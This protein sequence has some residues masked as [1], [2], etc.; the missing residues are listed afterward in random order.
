MSENP[1]AG[2]RLFTVEQANAALPLVRAIV[3]DL[4]ELYREVVERRQRLSSLT[5]GRERKPGDVY[6]QEVEQIEDE[7]ER[8]VRRLQEY[9]EELRQIGV[10][11]KS[12]PDG[13]VD[14]PAMIDGRPVYLCWK[15]G[16]PEVLYWHDLEAGFAGR[17]PLVAETG[18]SI[19]PADLRS[20]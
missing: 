18:T 4:A 9:V 16:E 10:E 14:F 2:R 1:F 20:S 17:Q 15:L 7:L 8:D 3:K 19:G 12:G 13:L 6:S 11:P 5:G